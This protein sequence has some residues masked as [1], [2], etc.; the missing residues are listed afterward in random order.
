[1]L[2]PSTGGKKKSVF[3]GVEATLSG[4]GQGAS[5]LLICLILLRLA[6]APDIS[7]CPQSRKDVLFAKAREVF[8]N[9]STVG[10]YYY[11]IRPYLGEPCTDISPRSPLPLLN[12]PL[13]LPCVTPHTQVLCLSTPHHCSL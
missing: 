1:M 3:Q 6:G 12:T 8:R 7:P 5:S 13:P 10:E 11:L 4:Q 2:S 9:T